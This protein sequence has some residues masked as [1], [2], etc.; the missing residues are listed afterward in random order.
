M[1]TLE[2]AAQTVNALEK[3]D[4]GKPFQRKARILQSLWRIENSYPIGTY[5]GAQRGVVLSMPWAKEN[6]ANF[7][8]TSIGDVVSKELIDAKGKGKMYGMPRLFNNL[9]SSQPMAFNL[10]AM[11]KLDLN[12]ATKVFAHLSKSRCGT[13]TGIEFEES[14]ARGSKEYTG[15][16]S[17]FD[18][19]VEFQRGQAKGFIGI[20][21]K[22]HEDLRNDPSDHHVEYDRVATDA[23]CFDPA[24]MAVLRDKPLQQIWRDH[25]LACSIL[26]KDPM[27]DGWFVFLSPKGNAACNQAV[28]KYQECLICRK[29]FEHWNLESVVAAIRQFSDDPWIHAF[30]DRYLNFAK[31]EKLITD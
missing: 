7:L 2:T 12:L 15:D 22:Y 24:K 25:L 5:R 21:V 6:M 20:E 1:T 27:A 11:L 31:V 26:Q 10:F 23:R 8:N 14:P 18:V 17:A 19:Y 29:T 9:L 28:E 4:N 13:V 30:E 3:I 16:H